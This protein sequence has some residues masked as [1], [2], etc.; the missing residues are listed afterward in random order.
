M[1]VTPALS[2]TSPS[3]YLVG[4]QGDTGILIKS[5]D[6]T[7]WLP[8]PTLLLPNGMPLDKLFNSQKPGFT[9]VT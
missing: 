8:V 6:S 1:L 3:M 5:P 2:K 9:S 7:A 4:Q